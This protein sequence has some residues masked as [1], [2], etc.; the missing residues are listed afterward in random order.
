MSD[1]G[2]LAYTVK[3]ATTALGIGR[4]LIYAEIRDGRLHARK[5]GRRTVIL[6]EDLRNW[7]EAQP[8]ARSRGDSRK[9]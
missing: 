4:T 9:W 8:A 7:L 2:R 5:I 6:R 1:D 3:Q